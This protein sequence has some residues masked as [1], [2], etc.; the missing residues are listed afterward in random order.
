MMRFNPKSTKEYTPVPTE[1]LPNDEAEPESQQLVTNRNLRDIWRRCTGYTRV[2]LSICFILTVI[3]S[4]GTG[5]IAPSVAQRCFK[6]STA[7][8]DGVANRVLLGEVLKSFNY[9]TAF[10]EEPPRGSGAGNIS[11]PAWDSLIPGKSH[12]ISSTRIYIVHVYAPSILLNVIHK[13]T[14]RM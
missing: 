14:S 2:L 9:S 3:V 12:T 13:L 11:E 10:S 8:R 7:T 1:T 4:F 6:I 5:M